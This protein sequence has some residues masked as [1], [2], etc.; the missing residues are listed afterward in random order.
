MK[1]KQKMI[2]I[3]LDP[4]LHRLLRLECADKEMSLQD[5]V[6]NLLEKNLHKSSFAEKSVKKKNKG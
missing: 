1:E 6:S 3:K 5:Y 2:H 4:K